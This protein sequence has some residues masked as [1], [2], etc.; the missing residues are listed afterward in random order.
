M[1][2]GSLLVATSCAPELNSADLQ[3]QR[4]LQ[5]AEDV[6]DREALATLYSKLLLSQ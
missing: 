6:V 5:V 4:A 3:A 1:Q 2:I